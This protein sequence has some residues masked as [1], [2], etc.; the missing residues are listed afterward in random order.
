[1]RTSLIGN[2]LIGPS[3]ISLNSIFNLYIIERLPVG[4]KFFVLHLF[5]PTLIL[6]NIGDAEFMSKVIVG[7]SEMLLL[8]SNK[9]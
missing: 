9:F 6:Y 4:G 1:M 5:L 7:L 8:H 2:D 3:I